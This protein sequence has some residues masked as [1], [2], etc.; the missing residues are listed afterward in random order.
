MS[1]MEL[2]VYTI[3]LMQSVALV[4][5]FVKNMDLT[6]IVCTDQY[7]FLN[8]QKRNWHRY[9]A[10][11]IITIQYIYSQRTSVENPLQNN[12]RILFS[13]S[14]SPFMCAIKIYLYKIPLSRQ[15]MSSKSISVVIK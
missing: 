1:H 10:I 3:R 13:I 5:I 6:H 12:A 7:N 8:K 11:H 9:S 15:N 2:K 14:L 4:V